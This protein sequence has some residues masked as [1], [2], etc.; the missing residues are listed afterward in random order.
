MSGINKASKPIKLHIGCETVYM[1]GWINIDN[2]SDNNIEKLDMNVDLRN[3][4]PFEDDSVDFIFNE[5]FLEHL[6]W[7]EGLQAIKEFM[8]VLKPGGVLRIAML[9]LARSVQIYEDKN[10]EINN[11]EYFEKCGMAF[12]ETRAQYLNIAFREWGH[13]HLYDFEELERLL[14]KA[15]CVNIQ[16]RFLHES[17]HEE[18]RNL[19]TREESTLIVDVQKGPNKS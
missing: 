11:I 10:W 13:K 8:R 3:R 5:H 2:N 17:T 19:E 4:L 6:T 9:D 7:D 12:I 14:K 18:L 16:K 1:D 15:G